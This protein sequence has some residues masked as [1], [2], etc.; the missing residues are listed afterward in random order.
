MQ[1]HPTTSLTLSLRNVLHRIQILV[2]TH[3]D[4]ASSNEN[5]SHYNA[6]SQFLTLSA[7]DEKT[8][9]IPRLRGYREG[10]GYTYDKKFVAYGAYMKDNAARKSGPLF[11]W[12]IER[13]GAEQLNPKR[14]P[15]RT[16]PF[17]LRVSRI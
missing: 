3:C 14:R 7:T 1:C 17:V 4:A 16:G 13:N 12:L 2:P 8:E 15:Y 11:P 10:L 5:H 6:A 9:K